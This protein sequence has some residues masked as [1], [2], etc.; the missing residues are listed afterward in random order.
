MKASIYIILFVLIA[1]E[2]SSGVSERPGAKRFNRKKVNQQRIAPRRPNTNSQRF[3]AKGSRQQ[4]IPKPRQGKQGVAKG[5][6]RCDF[7]AHYVTDNLDFFI[8]RTD[9]LFGEDWTIDNGCENHQLGCCAEEED[10]KCFGII[11]E[12]DEELEE[13]PR[14]FPLRRNMPPPQFCMRRPQRNGRFPN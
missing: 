2:L 5:S 1:Y 8:D 7:S 4:G 12:M 6:T 10:C 13:P 14:C 3:T 9:S 11:E